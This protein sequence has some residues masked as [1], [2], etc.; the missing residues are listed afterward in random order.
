MHETRD[1]TVEKVPAGQSKHCVAPDGEYWPASHGV[2]FSCPS[3]FW[4]VPAG[5]GKQKLEPFGEND[6]AGHFL[7][8]EEPVMENVPALQAVHFSE[9]S[10]SE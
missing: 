2:H 1:A 6:P 9:S 3:F 10:S 8:K 4:Y 5:Q 7:Q